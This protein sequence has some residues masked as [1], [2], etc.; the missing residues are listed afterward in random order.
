[1]PDR[2]ITPSTFNFNN[3]MS[4]KNLIPT[5]HEIRGRDSYKPFSKN[6]VLY[7]KAK[8]ENTD[9]NTGNKKEWSSKQT[10]EQRQ[11]SYDK[12]RTE[13]KAALLHLCESS[14]EKKPQ[15]DRL[16]EQINQREARSDG[17]TGILMG[18]DIKKAFEIF[19]SSS[20]VISLAS[21]RAIKSTA[22]LLQ[23]TSS[24]VTQSSVKQNHNSQLVESQSRLTESTLVKQKL[25]SLVLPTVERNSQTESRF[26]EAEEGL[27]KYHSNLKGHITIINPEQ[28]KTVC[29]NYAL[30][31]DFYNEDVSGIHSGMNEYAMCRP[32]QR[33]IRTDYLALL[34]QDPKAKIA[35]FYAGST[36]GHTARFNEELNEY[37]HTLPDSALFTCDKD[38]FKQ[39]GEYTKV[40]VFEPSMAKQ[41]QQEI[42]Q[43]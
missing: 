24:L 39:K 22:P 13:F 33:S 10:F 14:S 19:N 3:L 37:V 6:I 40:V 25:P 30:K 4:L 15:V 42:D 31:N 8:V 16:F 43:M 7:S 32:T 1:M 20:P 5:E 27:F 17:H 23:T 11:A 34:K 36:I 41:L 9:I 21:H 18:K 29:H 26:I 28:S 2:S 38:V 12:G 35:V